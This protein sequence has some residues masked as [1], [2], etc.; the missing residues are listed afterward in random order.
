MLLGISIGTLHSFRESLGAEEEAS[1]LNC[2][3]LR[4]NLDEWQPGCNPDAAEEYGNHLH[5]DSQ[6]SVV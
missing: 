5:G 2:Q 6:L 4:S 1:G 3:S